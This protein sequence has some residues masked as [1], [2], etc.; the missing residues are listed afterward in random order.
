MAMTLLADNTADT[1]DL[2]S[3][4]FTSGI[5]STYKLYIFKFLSINPATDSTEFSFQVNAAAGSGYNETITSTSFY[6]SHQ[7]DDGA[8]NLAYDAADDQAQGTAFNR[9]AENI[10]NGADETCSGTMW[11]FNPSNTTYVKHWYSRINGYQLS[12]ITYDYLFAGYIN[13]TSAID[14]IQFKMDSGNFDGTIKM[15]GVG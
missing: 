11:L 9:L 15:Y 3:V 6:A 12:N 14:E 10:G 2:A 8:T 13:T 4:S 5:D 7:E 1:T